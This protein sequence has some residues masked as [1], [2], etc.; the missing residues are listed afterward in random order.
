MIRYAVLNFY[1]LMI[2][3]VVEKNKVCMIIVVGMY[4]NRI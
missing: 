4:K 3:V 1:P 2:L